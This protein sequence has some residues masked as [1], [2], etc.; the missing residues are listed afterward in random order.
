VTH[1][2]E[3][4]INPASSE[5][6]QFPAKLA[7]STAWIRG[8][9][10]GPGAVK[11]HQ[12]LSRR[13]SYVFDAGAGAAGLKVFEA[14]NVRLLA[15]RIVIPDLVVVDTDDDEG[16]VTEAGEVVL[17]CEISSPAATDRLL[18]MQLYAAARIG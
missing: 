18:N 7:S 8:L 10:L 3:A 11:R 13:L 5:P 6:A 17:I 15:G 2:Y 12:D 9:H 14:I 4:R 16:A 1:K